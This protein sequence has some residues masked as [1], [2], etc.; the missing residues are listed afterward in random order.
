MEMKLFKEL[1]PYI[2]IVV[3]VVAI[4]AFIATPVRVDGAS[5][6]PT[7]EDG[8]ILILKKYDRSLERFDIVVL[9]YNGEKLVKRVIGLPGEKIAYKDNKLYVDGKRVKEPFEHEVTDDFELEEQI[10]EG[11]YFV[12][13][14]NR[15]NSTD[16]RMIG[17]ISKEQIQGTTNFSI[18]PFDK[19]GTVK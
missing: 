7:L 8:E 9:D 2:M 16:S 11:Y 3:V 5:M 13:G 15:I 18:F 10:P 12:L 19:F 1:L 14:D 17:A 4:R 6:N